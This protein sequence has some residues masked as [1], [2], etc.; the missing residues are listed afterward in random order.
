MIDKLFTEPALLALER[1]LDASSARAQI[2]AHN[3][4][5]A[6]TP[7]YKAVRLRFEEFL[8][9]ELGMD[10]AH[11]SLPLRRTHPMH[12]PGH[13]GLGLRGTLTPSGLVYTDERTT[14][15]LDGNNVDIDHETAEQA[16]NAIQYA[17]LTELASRRLATLQTAISEGRR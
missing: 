16:K 8:A 2:I 1:S 5:N 3:I 7:H 17:T 14:F 12:L 4:A 9:R 15:R 10:G 6:D 11:R 13:A